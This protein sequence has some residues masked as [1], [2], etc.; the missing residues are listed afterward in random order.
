MTERDW[1]QIAYCE[2]LIVSPPLLGGFMAKVFCGE[3]TLLMR[4]PLPGEVRADHHNIRARNRKIGVAAGTVG[5][6]GDFNSSNFG[7]GM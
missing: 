6:D 2:P 7:G 4:L 3:R 1:F 5:E